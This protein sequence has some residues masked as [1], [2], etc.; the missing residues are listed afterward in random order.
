[1]S[2][3]VKALIW[4]VVIL[5]LIGAAFFGISKIDFSETPK[6]FT[7]S[8]ADVGVAVQPDAS[9][10][11]TERL[12]YDFSGNFSGAYRDIPLAAGVRASNISVSERGKEFNPGGKTALGSFDLPGTFGATGIRFNGD[13]GDN[14]NKPT[15]GFRVVWH[16]TA[17]DEQRTFVISY[18][19]EGAAT[20]YDDVVD[21]D[22][23]IWGDQW[24]FWLDDIDA[25]VSLAAPQGTE[26]APLGGWVKSRQARCRRVQRRSDPSRPRSQ[27][28]PPA[29][30]R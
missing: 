29:S 2:A 8:K 27:G 12:T 1:M 19:I 3:V 14:D 5:G 4:R 7:I 30:R 21:V 11:I 15:Q 9:L 6:H 16:Y 28:F 26:S 10:K 22:W 24:D 23:A 25:T 17:T 20:A 18:D 13:S